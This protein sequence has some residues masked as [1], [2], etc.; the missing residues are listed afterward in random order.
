MHLLAKHSWEKKKK[1]STGGSK[2]VKGKTSNSDQQE[3]WV[4][5]QAGRGAWEE[6]T[7]FV[8]LYPTKTANR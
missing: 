7:G 5:R 1:S 8:S 4:L 6:V 2:V 3:I